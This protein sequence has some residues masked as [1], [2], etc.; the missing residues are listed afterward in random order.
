MLYCCLLNHGTL[1]P[2]MSIVYC[3]PSPLGDIKVSTAEVDDMS[4]IFI[5]AKREKSQSF[6]KID[7]CGNLWK[8]LKKRKNL[9]F[10]NEFRGLKMAEINSNLNHMSFFSRKTIFVSDS[11]IFIHI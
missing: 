7:E 1:G 3:T 6:I 8:P 10:N 9:I 2:Q 4:I 5:S 11:S